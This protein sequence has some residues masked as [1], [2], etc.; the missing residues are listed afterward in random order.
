MLAIKVGGRKTTAA[1]EKI[2]MIVFCS[3]LIMPKVASRKKFTLEETKLACSV[4]E[5]T[6]LRTVRQCSSSSW[7]ALARMISM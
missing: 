2:L 4:S 3:M 7:G 6:S 5:E 1:I